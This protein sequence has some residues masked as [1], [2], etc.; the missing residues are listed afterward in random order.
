MKKVKRK[1]ERPRQTASSHQGQAFQRYINVIP[2]DNTGAT[3]F[4]PKGSIHNIA[5]S[6]Q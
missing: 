3:R 2:R 6:M 4:F 1:R 5:S